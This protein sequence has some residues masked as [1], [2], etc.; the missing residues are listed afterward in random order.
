VSKAIREVAVCLELDVSV[1]VVGE[2]LNRCSQCLHLLLEFRQDLWGR[3]NCVRSKHCSV[4]DLHKPVLKSELHISSMVLGDH[5]EAF[6]SLQSDVPLDVAVSV[7][8]DKFHS[9][10]CS[11]CIC[12]RLGYLIDE[13]ELDVFSK[14][15]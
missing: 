8:N 12:F 7:V 13:E 6:H 2:C 14:I 5:S 11:V 15:L 10:S 1:I 4:Y 9:V 3:C